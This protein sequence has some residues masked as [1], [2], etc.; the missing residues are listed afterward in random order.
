M[1]IFQ[2]HKSLTYSK[3]LYHLFV[4][5]RMRSVM[6][7]RKTKPVLSPNISEE[8][9]HPSCAVSPTTRLGPSTSPPTSQPPP[10]GLRHSPKH[11][12]Q[13]LASPVKQQ[14][15]CLQSA[16]PNTA[17]N[18]PQTSSSSLYLQ[19]ADQQS[20]IVS[21]SGSYSQTVPTS[22][23][24]LDQSNQTVSGGAYPTPVRQS[25]SKT[26]F[27]LGLSSGQALSRTI[28]EN[29][30]LNQPTVAS[31]ADLRLA[32]PTDRINKQHDRTRLKKIQSATF[33]CPTGKH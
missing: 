1:L 6:L 2:T 28:A 27:L 17:L 29:K 9:V 33:M 32:L 4:F 12:N 11:S 7:D 5:L 23:S 16:N 20:G 26:S 22:L 18:L 10:P 3:Y 15:T 31:R 21:Y 14:P 13:S 19:S 24:L 25:S 30:N 8:M